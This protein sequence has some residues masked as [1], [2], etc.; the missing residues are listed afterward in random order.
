MPVYIARAF[1]HS[2]PGQKTVAVLSDWAFQIAKIE[3]GMAQAIIKVGNIKVERDYTDV[4]D[5]VLAYADILD[6]GQPGKPYNVCSG[7]G[8]KLSALLEKYQAMV[9]KDFEVV[10]DKSRQRP[11]DIPILTGSFERLKA[12]TGWEPKIPIETTLADSLKFW[13][14]RLVEGV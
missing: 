14:D 13:H 10:S 5:V 4:R 7:T 12:D 2:G 8:Y 1:S 11:I 6:K 3:L 9:K